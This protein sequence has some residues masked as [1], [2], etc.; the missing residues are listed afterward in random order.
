MM[1]YRPIDLAILLWALFASV[2]VVVGVVLVSNLIS[3]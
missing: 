3:Q 2:A 1:R